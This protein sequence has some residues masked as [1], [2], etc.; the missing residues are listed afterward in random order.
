MAVFALSACSHGGTARGRNATTSRKPGPVGAPTASSM[1]AQRCDRPARVG[2]TLGGVRI[3]EPKQAVKARLGKP[4]NYG[5]DGDVQVWR[6]RRI[7]VE[8]AAHQGVVRVE[9]AVRGP[10][11]DANVGVGSS[12]DALAHA[13]AG[14]LRSSFVAFGLGG[15]ISGYG[16]DVTSPKSG[17]SFRLRAG[18]VTTI[19][20]N[21]GCPVSRLS[22]DGPAIT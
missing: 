12:G 14:H 5:R 7:T 11:T 20:L 16:F 3:Y 17:L 19:R 1:P 21:G 18:R 4:T 2:E 13:Y 8:F 22:D 6:F 15:T 10:T 9:S